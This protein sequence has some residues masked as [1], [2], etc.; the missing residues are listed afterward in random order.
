QARDLA[1]ASEAHIEVP[2]V[3]VQTR[4][5]PSHKA[6]QGREAKSNVILA[7]EYHWWGRAFTALPLSLSGGAPESI[8][9]TPCEG[10]PLPPSRFPFL[11]EHSSRSFPLHAGEDLYR[12]PAFHFYG[13]TIRE[14]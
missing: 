12:P 2:P 4:A 6:P 5:Q 10:G 3:Q 8:I 13:S 1:V 14:H 9:S 11:R 7:V